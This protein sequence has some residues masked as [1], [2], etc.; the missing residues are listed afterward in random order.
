MHGRLSTSQQSSPEPRGTMVNALAHGLAI[1]RMFGDDRQVVSVAQI[2]REI[3]VHRSNASRLAATL[4][5][6]GF[7]D[8]AG[9]SGRYRLGPQ[10]VRLGRLADVNNDLTRQTLGPLRELVEKTGETGH[11]GILDGDQ[12]LTI[13]V[14]DGWHTVR[15]HSHVNKRS[16]AYCSS[17]GKVLLSG[18]DETAVR[19]LFTGRRLRAMTPHSLTSVAALLSELAVIRER[20]YALDVEELEIGLRCVS[21]PI[22]DAGGTTVASLGLSGP[23]LRMTETALGDLAELVRETAAKASAAIGGR[24]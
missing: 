11:I 14:V 24:A 15:M 4:H 5:A 12:A 17:M 10:L 13:A 16:P 8:R 7:L 22:R 18:L 6:M 20:G 2:A 1:L 3:E 9:E 19:R 23:A 21:A